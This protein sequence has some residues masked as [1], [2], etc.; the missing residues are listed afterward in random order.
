MFVVLTRRRAGTRWPLWHFRGW[1]LN[2]RALLRP[3][4]P[5]WSPILPLAIGPG[6]TG[7][8][9]HGAARAPHRPGVSAPDY[10]TLFARG[11]GPGGPAGGRESTRAPSG[12]G[13]VLDLPGPAGGSRQGLSPTSVARWWP[14]PAG[15]S[16]SARMTLR[17]SITLR[18]VGTELPVPVSLAV[19]SRP[20][21]RLPLAICQ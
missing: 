18:L 17:R 14:A 20:G 8:P 5:A 4:P 2:C 9:R 7:R 11:P 6:G 16:A 12:P 19:T 1:Q 10:L 13:P 21:V 15:P 3:V